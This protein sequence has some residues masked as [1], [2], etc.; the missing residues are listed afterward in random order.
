MGSL[1]NGLHDL[2]PFE[3]MLLWRRI[4]LWLHGGLIPAGWFLWSHWTAPVSGGGW[5]FGL[6]V[7]FHNAA[8]SSL[9]Q[10]GTHLGTS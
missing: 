6:S 5:D 7:V 1:G 3:Q 8:K 9:S 4:L 2:R 10:A